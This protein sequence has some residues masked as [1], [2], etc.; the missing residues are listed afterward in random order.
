MAMIPGATHFEI[1]D[2]TDLLVPMALSFL[3]AADAGKANDRK[4]F[5]AGK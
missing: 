2:R 4:F 3:D 5:L 1:L